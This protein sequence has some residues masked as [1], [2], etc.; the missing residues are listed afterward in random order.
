[1]KKLIFILFLFISTN[2]FAGEQNHNELYFVVEQKI[3]EYSFENIEN[4]KKEKICVF[5][6]KNQL[7]YFCNYKSDFPLE[8]KRRVDFIGKIGNTEYYMIFN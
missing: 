8:Y 7:I 4:T 3:K 5:N 2:I 6:S 1:M